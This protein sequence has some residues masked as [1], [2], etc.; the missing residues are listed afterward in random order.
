MR[1][2]SVRKVGK[3]DLYVTPLGFGAGPIGTPDVTNE[4][5]LATVAAAWAS[6]VRFYDT[7]P[8]Y[9]MGRS[10]RRLGLALSGR[11]D[12]A[13]YRI[14]T[15]VGKSL[16]PEPVP[17]AANDTHC[18]DGSMRTPRDPVTGFRIAFNYTHD[19][20][21]AQH[22]DSLQRLG[23]SSVDSLTI[24]DVDYGYHTPE[25][26]AGHLRELARDGGGGAAALEEL[27]AAG[28]IK[29]IGCGCNLE[30]RNR[31]SW[32]GGAHEAL[33]ERILDTVD[34]DFLAIAGAYT[35][36]ETCALD[37]IMPLCAERGVGVIGATPYASGWLVA[38]GEAGTYMYAPPPRAI[39]D[40]SR[41]MQA[42]CRAHGV[43]LAAAAIQF[44]LAHPLV[45]AVIPGARSA[46]EATQNAAYL[47]TPIPAALWS[48]FKREGLLPAAAPTPSEEP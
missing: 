29:A 10:E 42:I 47:A 35:L 44:P 30:A 33:I 18:I 6:G 40:K 24:H 7:A 8:L 19:A 37:R 45:A 4:A 41:R 34:L 14:N 31:A 32:P 20:L 38:P 36:L 11:G 43:P 46:A 25:Q 39:V 15:K 3:S 2:T 23:H 13:A 5:S 12:R 48:E 16:V 1:P 27:R 9:G 21:C 26:I 22:R 28:R 17:N